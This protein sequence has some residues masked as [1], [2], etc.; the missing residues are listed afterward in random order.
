[1][2]PLNAWYA[3][4]WAAGE[5]AGQIITTS[6]LIAGS[7][8]RLVGTLAG[9]IIPELQGIVAEFDVLGLPLR[10]GAAT[11]AV[12]DLHFDDATLLRLAANSFHASFISHSERARLLTELDS[13]VL[14]TAKWE[15]S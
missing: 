13:A 7:G 5:C 6:G 15:P 9:A 12:S 8:S 4:G 14:A 2:F 1:M 10:R 11:E 3:V